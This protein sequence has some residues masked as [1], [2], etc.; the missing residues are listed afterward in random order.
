VPRTGRHLQVRAGLFPSDAFRTVLRYHHALYFEQQ[1]TNQQTCTFTTL[2]QAI[3]FAAVYSKKKKS[4][5]IHVTVRGDPYGCETSR[6][7]HFLDN[8]LTD[9]VE[10]S[11]LHVGHPLPPGRFL[12]LIS[13]RGRVD[14]RAPAAAGRIRSIEKSKD[15]GKRTRDLMACSIVP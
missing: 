9:G 7:P 15:I 10:L 5:A 8:R 6:L 11:A 13:V 12:V 1:N 2:N 4:K 3:M 14:R